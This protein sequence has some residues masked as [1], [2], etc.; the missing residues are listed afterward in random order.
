MLME[1][2]VENFRSIKKPIHFSMIASKDISHTNNLIKLKSIKPNLLKV[3]SI[4][5]SNASGKSN[6]LH[7]MTMLKNLVKHSHS[8][9]SKRR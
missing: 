2:T 1:F 8:Y 3:A 4:Y 6:V 7:A 9:K 5:G